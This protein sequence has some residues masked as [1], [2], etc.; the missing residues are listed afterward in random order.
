ML[1]TVSCTE[2]HLTRQKA[3]VRSTNLEKEKAKRRLIYSVLGYLG[4]PS[5]AH[6]LTGLHAEWN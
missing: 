4:W 5:I 6:G 3:D 1:S 2:K